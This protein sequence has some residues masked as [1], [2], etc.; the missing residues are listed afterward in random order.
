[1]NKLISI[2]VPVYKVEAYLTKCIESLIKQSYR[3]IEIIL[4]DD[5]SPDKCGNICDE[6]AKQDNR[7]IVIHKPNGG[8]SS[9]RNIG[10]DICK[11]D[12]IMFADS[13]DWVEPSFCEEAIKLITTMGVECVSFGYYDYTNENN[14]SLVT[15]GSRYISSE[16]AIE[17][18]WG[19]K[20]L[21]F[22]VV[23]NKIFHRRL[24]N[25][26]RFPEGY[27]FEDNAV[28]HRIFDLAKNIYLSDL[29]LYTYRRRLG[30][31]TWTN[32]TP[33]RAN[34]RF[35]IFSERLHFLKLHYPSIAEKQLIQLAKHCINNLSVIDWSNNYDIKKK[36]S[37]FLRS[38]KKEILKI[39]LPLKIKIKL[40]T[41]YHSK[42]LF[43]LY[44]NSIKFRMFNLCF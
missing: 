23:W 40:W 34:D 21:F 17:S 2:I 12:Y 3:N 44:C 42:P 6:F 22:I 1:M 28:T 14:K 16:E 35:D 24:F 36:F 31:A 27:M 7:I 25:D 19:E 8:V 10:L 4:I 38:N 39:N 13:D 20:A 26:I 9:A 41:Y 15:S 18:I 33:R 37:A 30:S 11:G 29:P 5:G 43:E 32:D